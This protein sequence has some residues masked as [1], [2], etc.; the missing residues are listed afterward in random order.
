MQTYIMCEVWLILTCAMT[1]SCLWHDSLVYRARTHSY[2]WHDLFIYVTLLDC[3]CAMTQSSVWHDSSKRAVAQISKC[4]SDCCSVLQSVAVRWVCVLQL[5]CSYQS[6]SRTVAVCS[7]VLQCVA[8]WCS[9]CVAAVAQLSNGLSDSCSVLQCIAAC[10]L[11]LLRSYQRISTL[12]V[13]LV[14]G[15]CHTL[16]TDTK[17]ILPRSL[18]SWFWILTLLL[19]TYEI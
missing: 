16:Y 19:G 15:S 10:V 1:N 5:L 2:V 8:T 17:G 13:T 11:Q 12:G 7:R 14:N 6:V 9:V 4:L 3:T 18:K